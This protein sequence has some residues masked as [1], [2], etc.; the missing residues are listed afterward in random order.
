MK[1]LVWHG[2]SDIRCEAVPDPK[3][4]HGRDAIIKVTACASDLHIFDGVIPQMNSGDFGG[5]ETMGE[6][7]EVGTENKKLKV[8]D[9]PISCRQA[10]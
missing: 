4:E 6:V 10:C 7:V 5:H 8:G 2:K 1:A 9:S 3:I